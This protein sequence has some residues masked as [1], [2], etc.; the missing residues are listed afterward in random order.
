MGSIAGPI[1]GAALIILLPEYFRQLGDARLLIFG[2]ALVV[3][4][5]IRPQGLIQ[6]RRRAAELVSGEDQGETPFQPRDQMQ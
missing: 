4:M 1:L 2:L 3:V 5:I 6:N